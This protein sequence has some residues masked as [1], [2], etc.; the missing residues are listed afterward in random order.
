MNKI[1]IIIIYNI[2]IHNTCYIIYYIS[3]NTRSKIAIIIT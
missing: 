2:Y 3:N 1:L